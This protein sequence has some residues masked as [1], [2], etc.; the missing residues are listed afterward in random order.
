VADGRAALER[1]MG[2]LV[3]ANTAR[4]HQ[5][6][7]ADAETERAAEAQRSAAA[8]QADGDALRARLAAREAENSELMAMC[9]L[10]LAK[11][12]KGGSGGQ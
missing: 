9:D 3:A 6:R 7:R 12:E 5:Q 11:A 2:Q 1:A 8:L 4:E 10:L